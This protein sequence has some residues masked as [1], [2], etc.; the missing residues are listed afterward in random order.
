MWPV[1][2][3]KRLNRLGCRARVARCE[4]PESQLATELGET[5]QGCALD[6]S[7]I[8]RTSTIRYRAPREGRTFLCACG[9]SM[10][11]ATASLV[12]GDM[13]ASAWSCF[14]RETIAMMPIRTNHT[15]TNHRR[16]SRI[17][18][19]A[20]RCFSLRH[21]EEESDGI[22]TCAK[23]S[24]AQVDFSSDFS[25]GPAPAATHPQRRPR[26]RMAPT[27]LGVVPSCICGY[28]ASRGAYSLI[29]RTLSRA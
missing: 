15:L 22:S 16:L 3:T 28:E 14:W 27:R 9:F 18:H 10:D 2:R 5:C 4:A 7:S 12:D 17:E 6:R 19:L 23:L 8:L 29:R 1:C 26:F 21:M 25:R 11:A 20:S 24:V 13:G